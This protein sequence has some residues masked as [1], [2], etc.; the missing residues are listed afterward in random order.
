MK[1]TQIQKILF[2]L[3]T[4]VLFLVFCKQNFGQA[5]KI[6]AMAAVALTVAL[7]WIFEVLPL[8]VTAFLP[9]ALYPLLGIMEAKKVAPVYMSSVLMLFIGGF[10][11]ALAMRRWDLHKRIA[12]NIISFFGNDP[13]GLILGFMVATSFLSMWISNTATTVMMVSIALAVINN[14]EQMNGENEK[15]RLFSSALMMSI[16]YSATIG[17]IATL[18]GTPP[19]IAFIRIFSLSFPDLPEVTFGQWLSFGFP[20][21]VLLIFCAYKI[22]VFKMIRGKNIDRIDQEI[23]KKQKSS[24]GKMKYEEKWVLFIFIT[25]ALL[26][27]FRKDLNLGFLVIP[28]WSHLLQTPQYL[29]DGTVAIFMALLLFAIPSKKEKGQ[30]IL[31][32]KALIQI[33]WHTIILFGG[34]FALAKGVQE[35]GLS[36]Y[37]GQ[38]LISIKDYDL[39]FIVFTLTAGMSFLTELASNMASTEMLLPI[40]ASISKTTEISPYLLMIPATLASSSAFMLPA[41]TAPNAIIFGSEKVQIMDMVKVGIWINLVFILFASLFSLFIVPILFKI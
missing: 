25:L 8:A 40:L 1:K 29:D 4:L 3:C 10:F 24:L 20:L 23:I 14:Y 26:W 37:L 27:I 6:L 41:A 33:P 15:T 11:I 12:L 36:L 17:G 22:I 2:L 30:K 28:G 5:N 13:Q 18:V 21:A 39:T 34:G 16:A 35:S 9:V 32:G 19:N 7:W 31:D 38:Q